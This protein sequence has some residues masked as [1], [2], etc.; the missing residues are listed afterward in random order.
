MWSR[1]ELAGRVELQVPLAAGLSVVVFVES[2]NG[3]SQDLLLAS[4]SSL[5]F[6][7]DP[8]D[9]E[10]WNNAWTKLDN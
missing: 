3:H 2:T 7:N 6:W 10:D 8:P 4:H 1:G 5:D 9:D